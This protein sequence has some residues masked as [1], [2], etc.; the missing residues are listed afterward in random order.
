MFSETTGTMRYYFLLIF[1]VGTNISL[2]ASER[3]KIL[4]YYPDC[5]YEV[6]DTINS[7][8]RTTEPESAQTTQKLL[9]IILDKAKD[10]GAEALILTNKI[11]D[12]I[13]NDTR[14][15]DKQRHRVRY[16]A[17]LIKLCGPS[18]PL[19]DKQTPYD[20]TGKKAGVKLSLG[21][22]PG[23][24]IEPILIQPKSRRKHQIQDNAITIDGSVYGVRLGTQYEQALNVLGDPNVELLLYNNELVLGYGRS[25]W[26]SFQNNQ[27]VKVTQTPPLL[28]LTGKNIIPLIDYFDDFQWS[29]EG[30]LPYKS[31][32][33]DL[34]E[35][36]KNYT[37]P[38]SKKRLKLKEDNTTLLLDLV[39]CRS[40]S[41]LNATIQGFT[42]I[43]KAF[44]TSQLGYSNKDFETQFEVISDV[45]SS[46]EELSWDSLR[47][48]LGSI[49]GYIYHSAQSKV[50]L[51]N[52]NLTLSIRG[53]KITEVNVSDDLIEH[54]SLK[55]SPWELLSFKQGGDYSELKAL[56][57][58]DVFDLGYEVSFDKDNY[59]LTLSFYDDGQTNTLY[60]MN[61]AIK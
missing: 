12:L 25:H 54:S 39:R 49:I 1:V 46:G 48:R 19:T 20:S 21:T 41:C 57:P 50:V 40:K 11:Y 15:H 35:A 61:V 6:I 42:L 4:N 28:T 32:L 22:I 52:P 43:S 60:E 3:V 5:N 10:K 37:P 53:D 56:F 34:R 59:S 2:H 7:Q 29:I 31:T 8:L 55:K 33:A 26:F 38:T 44:K 30:K 23:I 27:L 18:T 36:L 13:H 24:V 58:D 45:I 47:P 17:E 9:N 51:V 14:H 16:D